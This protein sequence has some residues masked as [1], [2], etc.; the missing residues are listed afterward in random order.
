MEDIKNKYPVFYYD[1]NDPD[2][3]PNV[4]LD[5]YTCLDTLAKEKNI[6]F[7]VLPKCFDKEYLDKKSI[8]EQIDAIRK[9]V[10][11]WED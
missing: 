3:T 11:Q 1:L 9:D 5:A 2:I 4:L 10:E 7:V 6:K 8:L